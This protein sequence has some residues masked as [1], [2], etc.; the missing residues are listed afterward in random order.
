MK[1]TLK[2]CLLGLMALPVLGVPLSLGQC[3]QVGPL[4]LRMTETQ[5]TPLLGKPASESKPVLEGATGLTIKTRKYP[6]QGVILTLSREGARKPW[7]LERFRVESPSV[8]KTP[9]G[10][11]LG[12][13]EEQIRTTY[14]SLID[15][16][17]TSPQQV[18]VG[19]VYDGVIFQLNKG[20]VS[21]IFVGAAA[22]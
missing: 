17:S 7:L 9:Q 19:T 14:H 12:A 3:Q 11:G 8:W 21:S 1:R 2:L 6:K 18:V 22:E 4:K 10:I 16:E 13:G 5:L 15:S 20:K